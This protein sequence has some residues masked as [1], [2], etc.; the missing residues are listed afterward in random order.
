MRIIRSVAFLA[1][2]LT[3]IIGTKLGAQPLDFPDIRSV[4]TD[5]VS[6]A[7]VVAEPAAGRRVRHSIHG[8]NANT[9]YHSL[10][11]P[12]DWTSESKFPV[13]VEFSGNGGYQN[14]FG[15]TSSGRPEGSC[16]GFGL[17]AGKGAIW[18]CLPCLNAAGADIAA[19]WWGDA[20]DYDP[21]S[22]LDY[23]HAAVDDAC[24]NFGGD[25]S[26]LILCGFS[27]GSIA[28]N[29]LGLHDDRTA[30]LWRAF[31]PY[32]HYDGVRHWPYP[33]SDAGSALRRLERLNHR[34]QFI[35]GEANQVDE[36]RRFIEQHAP[37][38]NL[39]FDSTGFRNHSDAWILRPSKARQS[40][41]TWMQAVLF[42]QYPA[43]I[44]Y[45]DRSQLLLVRDTEGNERPVKT[46][47][48]WAERV[49]HLRASMQLVM[50]PLPD[51]SRRVPLNLQVVSEESLSKYRRQKIWFTPEPEDRVPAW[52]LIPNVLSE[53]TKAPAMLCLHQTTNI[54]K[55]EPAGLG[56]SPSLHYAHE[57]AERGFVCIVPDYP[58]FGEYAFDF[59][60]NGARYAS[61]SMKAIWNNI[62]AVDVLES[63]PQVDKNRIGTIGHSLGGHNSL[64]TAVFDERLR[65]V[66]TSCGFTPFHDYYNGKLVGWTSDRYMPRI[67]DEYDNNADRVPF[68]F[69]EILASIAP[70]SVY[71]NS[72]IRDSNFDVGGVRKAFA[73]AEKVYAL[74]EAS[75][76]N[77]KRL[78]L[79]TPDAPH[80]FPKQERN[81]AY[82]WLSRLP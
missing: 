12:S 78:T 30:K 65:S 13:I 42:H 18:L 44:A 31:V 63:L 69:Y 35:C 60:T 68:D 50:G 29:F 14:A 25:P 33:N 73:Q 53:N 46:K 76:A 54:G 66:V 74:F 70:R 40:L 6:P 71:S 34:S 5:L 28:C 48:D 17:S 37:S 3:L 52:L 4:E 1:F 38:A 56:G 80:D 77:S 26:R 23:L 22:T 82:E 39:I 11:L 9:V 24:Q 32:S 47:A 8:W 79:S 64:F 19:T 27:R 67:R 59:K 49:S 75:P 72:P 36:S 7:M 41:R 61:G 20:P 15:D 16:L 21:K 62:R 43:Q 81:A 58:S 2:L 45:P 57:L 55:D 51:S 10:Y